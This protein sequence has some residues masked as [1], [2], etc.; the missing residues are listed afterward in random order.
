MHA[1]PKTLV[2]WD[3]QEGRCL[4]LIRKLLRQDTHGW[5]SNEQR[6]AVKN[7]LEN[8]TDTINILKTGGG[9]SMLAILP[10]LLEPSATLVMV[11]FLA[12]IEDWKQ[13]LTT[14]GIRFSIYQ[15][16][17]HLNQDSQIVLAST[18]AAGTNAFKCKIVQFHQSTPIKRIVFDEAHTSVTEAGYRDTLEDAYMVRGYLGSCQVNLLSATIPPS[19]IRRVI[20][21]FR[22]VPNT[23]VVRESSLRP[24]LK[25]VLTHIQSQK[26]GHHTQLKDCVIAL[27]KTFRPHE[28]IIVFV[29]SKKEGE[30]ISDFLNAP[31]YYSGLQRDQKQDLQRKF[32]SATSNLQLM[33]ATSAFSTGIDYPSIRAVVYYVV[34]NLINMVEFAQGSARA[35][36]DGK[37]SKVI[38]LADSGTQAHAASK[39]GEEDFR[40]KNAMR[41]LI[42]NAGKQQCLRYGL[43]QFL[44]GTGVQCTEA[45]PGLK[46]IPCSVCSEKNSHNAK[47]FDTK[48]TPAPALSS[49]VLG[50]RKESDLV[51]ANGTASRRSIHQEDGNVDVSFLEMA[52]VS[53]RQRQEDKSAINVIT[54]EHK[55]MLNRLMKLCMCCTVNK[56][57]AVTKEHHLFRCP[58]MRNLERYMDF[59]KILVYGKEADPRCNK[60]HVP[61]Y[62][63]HSLHKGING[64]D[65]ECKW[66]DIVM[67]V[68]YSIYYH[69][70]LQWKARHHFKA[71]YASPSMFS[72]WGVSKNKKDGKSNFWALLI[73]YYR[74]VFSQYGKK[75][76]RA[77]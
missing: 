69:P 76:T 15:C 59:K 52:M 1:A 77:I 8:T 45:D 27:M 48:A 62:Q 66:E 28:K 35:G 21:L 3:R 72:E 65:T 42:S 16:N 34:G 14:M 11:P 29:N 5:K 63:G 25:Y 57:V 10:T 70:E 32:T 44:D 22:L 18:D 6:E 46:L 23:K 30:K 19:M 7:I 58:E 12:L 9:K 74:D 41:A 4:D 2:S 53:K 26:A 61:F 71:T 31:F 67:P 37:R 51:E 13:R 64:G 17:S 50:K 38:L 20:D 39:N 40:G 24:E 73:W 55:A 49:V 43:T 54:Q 75:K 36:R 56:G 68:A 33:V 47:D 60:C